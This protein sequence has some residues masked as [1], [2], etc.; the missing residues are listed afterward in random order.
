MSI[1]IH[2]GPPGSY[3]T[4]GAVHEDFVRAVLA[5]RHIITN[6]RGL[7]DRGQVLSVLDGRKPSLFSKPWRVPESFKLTYLDTTDSIQMGQVRR[8]FHW[9]P[10]GVFFL[11]DEIQEIY[12][13]DLTPA[14]I[15]EFD[16][17]EGLDAATAAGTF[18][19]LALA[20]E[21]HRHKNWDFVVTTPN[22]SK[23]HK[24]VRGSAEAAYRHKNLAVIGAIFKGS[25]NETFHAPDNNGKAKTDQN[26]VLRKKIPQWVF[27]LYK[28][29]Q[30][31]QVSDT[32][33]GSSI[34]KDPKILFFIFILVVVLVYSF[35]MG[36]PSF[37]KGTEQ[38]NAEREQLNAQKNGLATA[39]SPKASNQTSPVAAPTALPPNNLPPNPVGTGLG[40]KVAT[41][42]RWLELFSSDFSLAYTY[43]QGKQFF[44]GVDFSNGKG[45]FRL[46]KNKLS[47]L[48]INYQIIDRCLIR[49]YYKDVLDVYVTCPKLQVIQENHKPMAVSEQFKEGAFQ[50]PFGH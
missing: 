47:A 36:L 4:A 27:S 43:Y 28:S 18:E 44:Y 34:F 7:S 26:S 22:I 11:L 16:Y 5:G 2:H 49:L 19:T 13:P 9:S 30:T 14:K 12:P 25:Y 39:P 3:K 42:P 24:L 35:S 1:K 23:V 32:T 20:F 48:G 6:V 15:K 8:F 40:S 46:D 33:A 45:D 29:T 41:A 10:D 37:M 38:L 17:P 50:N 21:K 31:G